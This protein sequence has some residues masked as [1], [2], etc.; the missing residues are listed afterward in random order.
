MDKFI[1]PMAELYP[2]IADKLQDGGEV[3]FTVTGH[4]MQPMLYHRRDAVTIKKPDGKI[5]KNDVIFY[6]R[7]DGK[8]VLH[9]VVKCQ[10][11]GNF[12]CLGDNQ[13][14]KEFD[15]R[16]DQIIGV[17]TG[18][19]RNGKV[20]NVKKSVGY[21]FYYTVWPLAHHFKPLYKYVRKLKNCLNK[22]IC[23]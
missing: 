7:D 16:Y 6:R 18:F 10:K 2:L 5:L 14:Q 12:T 1:L 8:F 15:L 20:V 17:A 4:S 22:K 23:K 19:V 3:T 11:N 21:R 13:W 9:R